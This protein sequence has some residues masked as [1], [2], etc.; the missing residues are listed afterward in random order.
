MSNQEHTPDIAVVVMAR[1]PTMGQTKTRLART[2]GDN[3]TLHLYRA[4]LTDLIQHHA[5]QAYTLCWT[6][7]PNDVDY[8][9]LIEMLAHTASAS[10]QHMRY[11]SQQGA[12]LAE[13]LHYAFH[14]THDQGYQH[15]FVIGSDSPQI[16]PETIAHAR[17]ALDEADVVLGPSD[18]GG[19]YLIGM[20]R[21][22]DVFSNIPMST[23]RVT[24]M[25][26]QAAQRQG[27]RVQTIETLFDVDEMPDL[28]RLAAL[29]T[30]N[31]TLAPTT[32]AY[33]EQLR[34]LS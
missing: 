12:D 20:K 14:W 21:P 10:V 17:A 33:L 28:Q 5:S 9:T 24:E 1:Y 11:F 29:L 32:A 26:I 15:T 16:R 7:T 4:F 34:M 25:T 23:S 8:Q 18:D 27:L 22:Y 13:R 19:Y 2:L 6:Y 30:H 3:N 31:R